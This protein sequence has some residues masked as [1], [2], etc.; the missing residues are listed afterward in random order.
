MIFSATYYFFLSFESIEFL[1]CISGTRQLY[2]N[3]SDERDIHPFLSPPLSFSF[4]FGKSSFLVGGK[5]SDLDFFI[6]FPRQIFS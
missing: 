5:R 1:F 6:F 2:F 4:F 3:D